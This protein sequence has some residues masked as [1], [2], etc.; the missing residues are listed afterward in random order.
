MIPWAHSSLGGELL[1]PGDCPGWWTPQVLASGVSWVS[2][3]L[4]VQ[5]GQ[6]Y[7]WTHSAEL[8]CFLGLLRFIY[9]H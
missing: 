3:S 5:S 7:A 9:S 4:S 2:A 1:F 6:W 8:D